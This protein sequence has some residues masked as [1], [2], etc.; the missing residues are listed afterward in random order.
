MSTHDD[1]RLEPEIADAFALRLKFLVLRADVD[2]A[3]D[4]LTRVLFNFPNTPTSPA[5]PRRIEKPE[6]L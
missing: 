2:E 1:V 6:D 5:Q 3:I 4:D